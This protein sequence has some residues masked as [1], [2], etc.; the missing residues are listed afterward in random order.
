M[1]IMKQTLVTMLL[2]VV[3]LTAS[4]EDKKGEGLNEKFFNARVAE[5]VYR[6]DLTEEQQAKFTPIYRRY[7]EEMRATMGP[8]GK[9]RHHDGD[10]KHEGDCKK[11]DGDCKKH[12]GDCKKKD[13]EMKRPKAPKTDEERLA[14]TK[15]RM[16][17][18]QKAQAIRLRYV[19]EFATVLTADQVS[20]FFDIE[21]KIQQKMMDR[22]R[23]HKG[24]RMRGPGKGHFGGPDKAPRMQKND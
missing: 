3:A 13:G 19:D 1:K 21:H 2:M 5:M 17:R 22:R 15:E 11:H 23:H 20:R 8:H 24:D 4:A 10:C 6:L 16:E 12:D 18:Q 7:C 9:R 14:R